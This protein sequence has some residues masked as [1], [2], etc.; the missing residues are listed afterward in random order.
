MRRFLSKLAWIPICFGLVACEF[1]VSPSGEESDAPKVIEDLAPMPEGY[2]DFAANSTY[3]FFTDGREA[4]QDRLHP[5][6]AE[7]S[8]L[9]WSALEKF[10]SDTADFDAAKYYGHGFFEEEGVEIIFIQLK[11]PFENGYNLVR[12]MMP[13]NEECCRIAGV[14]IDAEMEKS[15]AIGK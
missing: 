3:L 15:F 13:L 7:L 5:A 14:Q 8:S 11:I 4:I 10:A 6:M 9:K 12:V 2:L 1:S